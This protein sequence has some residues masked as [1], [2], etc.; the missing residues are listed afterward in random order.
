MECEKEEDKVG[1]PG[2]QLNY[3]VHTCTHCQG[4]TLFLIRLEFGEGRQSGNT[5][6]RVSE[7]L[8]LKLR[9]MDGHSYQGKENR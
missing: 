5:A 6:G 8:I 2:K 9:G 1:T 7:L 4:F 3:L